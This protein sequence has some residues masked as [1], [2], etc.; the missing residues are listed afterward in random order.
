MPVLLFGPVCVRVSSNLWISLYPEPVKPKL[1]ETL[2]R[3]YALDFVP[4]IS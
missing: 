4:S 2:I 3:K 1:H